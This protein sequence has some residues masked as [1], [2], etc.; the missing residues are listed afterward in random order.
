MASALDD[1]I[2]QIYDA[3]R[4]SA[5]IFTFVSCQ[6]K[7]VG[8]DKYY[9][10]NVNQI[11]KR[12]NVRNSFT[13]GLIKADYFN[14]SSGKIEDLGSDAEVCGLCVSGPMREYYR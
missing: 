3:A 11:F 14:I 10:S 12:T 7:N 4:A 2:G 13:L 6:E 8:F 5:K 1:Y 9:L